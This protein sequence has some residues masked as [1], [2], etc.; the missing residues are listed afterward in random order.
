MVPFG[1]NTKGTKI[2]SIANNAP[3]KTKCERI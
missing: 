2:D 3:A 1:I